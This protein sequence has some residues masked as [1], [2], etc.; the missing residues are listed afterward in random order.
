MT[1]REVQRLVAYPNPESSQQTE[2]S[3]KEYGI[4]KIILKEGKKR[5]IRLSFKI[6]GSFVNDLKRT[7][8]GALTT[9]GL[10]VGEYR[11]LNKKEINNL[12]SNS[13]VL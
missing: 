7:R 11:T 8:I 10:R 6:L 13:S 3:K 4:Y 5:Q 2:K 9:F 1:G 12:K